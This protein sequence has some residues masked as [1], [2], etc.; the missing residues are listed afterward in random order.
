MP[1]WPATNVL[2]VCLAPVFITWPLVAA[3]PKEEVGNPDP[4]WPTTTKLVL[5][6]RPA[7]QSIHTHQGTPCLLETRIIC[8]GVL[9]REG[10]VNEVPDV[11]THFPQLQGDA[12]SQASLA[13]E[14]GN[15]RTLWVG[16]QINQSR[17]LGELHKEGLNSPG[18][19]TGEGLSAGDYILHTYTVQ[20]G[21]TSFVK[22]GWAKLCGTKYTIYR[23]QRA[24]C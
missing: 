13:R 3:A 4:P 23:L 8:F 6:T 20:L 19:T 2:P 12:H 21:A 9:F 5:T 22:C 11:T 17:L 14:Q 24:V 16:G 10:K 18:K 1:Q 15:G 7:R